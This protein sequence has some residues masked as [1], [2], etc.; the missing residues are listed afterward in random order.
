MR[1]YEF[2]NETREPPSKPI[3]LRA[4]HK[5]KLEQKRHQASEDKRHALMQVMYSDTESEQERNDIERQRLEL[6]QLRA[7]IAATKADT[8]NKSAIA[9][10]HS[11]KQGLKSRQQSQQHLTK[12][13]KSG[14]GREL[15][16]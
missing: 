8:K 5:M 2:I 15:K 12:L 9:L 3:T 16:P 10:Q 13:A 4:L 6:E 7:E 14:I 11:A 1:A